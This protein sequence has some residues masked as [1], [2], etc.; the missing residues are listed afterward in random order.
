MMLNW[1]QKQLAKFK[2][3]S[4]TLINIYIINH[5]DAILNRNALWS[6]QNVKQHSAIVAVF[7]YMKKYCY[8]RVFGYNEDR[9]INSLNI[10]FHNCARVAYGIFSGKLYSDLF[11]FL[12]FSLFY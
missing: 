9:L 3:F 2:K 4:T 10:L 7:H 6:S 1:F 8:E 11:T 12:E 5:S